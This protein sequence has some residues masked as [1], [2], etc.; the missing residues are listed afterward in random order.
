MKIEYTEL[1]ALFIK[2]NIKN[3]TARELTDMFNAHF[4]TNKSVGAIRMWCNSRGLGK[5]FLLEPRYTDAQLTFIYANKHLTNKELTE[6]FNK[7]FGTHKKTHNLRDLR[8]SRGWG[9]EHPRE[10]SKPNQLK[11]I[12]LNGERIRLDVYVYECV[13]GK[14]PEGYSVIHLDDDY[15][16]N[17]INNL[18]A[19]PAKIR[20]SFAVYGYS[21]MPKILAP[22][23]YAQT[24][25][26]HAIK[27]RLEQLVG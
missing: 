9:L 19:A 6:K 21:K 11:K 25:L 3:S 20:H 27:Q 10:F 26:R 4:G 18:H 7:R 14:L 5:H 8:L 22:A 24:I 17:N 23:L 15:S 2:E 12:W 1:Q 13:H 16:N